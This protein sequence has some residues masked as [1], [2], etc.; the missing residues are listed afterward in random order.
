MAP[1]TAATLSTV[2][3][4]VGVGPPRL[5]VPERLPLLSLTRPSKGLAPLVPLKVAR[6]VRVD[7]CTRSSRN[8]RLRRVERTV[9]AAE[10]GW[11]RRVPVKSAFR[12]LS[13]L[14]NENDMLDLQI[15]G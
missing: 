10:R 12:F 3:G 13:Q 7:G 11:F 2:P 8:S 14:V 4:S 6:V 5:V 15:E 1:A 9:R